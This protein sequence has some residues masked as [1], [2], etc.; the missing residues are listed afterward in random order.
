MKLKKYIYLLLIALPL[1]AH[2]EVFKCKN[3][4]GKIIYQSEPCSSGEVTQGVINVKQMTPEE[5]ELAK[6]KLKVWQEQQAV[7]DAANKAT[8]LERQAELERQQSLELQRRSVAAQEQQAIAAQQRSYTASGGVYIPAYG[9]NGGNWGY[10]P[11]PQPYPQYPQYPPPGA[12]NPNM[13]PQQPNNSW[14]S[15]MP[16]QA[17]PYGQPAYQPPTFSPHPAAPG[18]N[19]YRQ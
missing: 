9:Y 5:T 18:T 19:K 11:Y 3:A 1:S 4:I 14:N 8:E 15:N 6:A 7:E 2:A 16:P 10:R 13:L 17:Q 12:W